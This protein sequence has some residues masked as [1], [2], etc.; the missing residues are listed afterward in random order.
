MED[1]YMAVLNQDAKCSDIL[2]D[3][4]KSAR[5]LLNYLK[6]ETNL[7]NY[8]KKSLRSLQDNEAIALFTRPRCPAFF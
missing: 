3:F 8:K 2:N 6:A 4:N 5:S 7:Y 1:S